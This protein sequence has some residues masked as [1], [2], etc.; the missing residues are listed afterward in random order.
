MTCPS[1][2]R[3]DESHGPLA[4]KKKNKKMCLFYKTCLK[5]SLATG[6]CLDSYLSDNY[7][8]GCGGG[9]GSGGGS[10]SLT[11]F[12]ISVRV[13]LLILIAL[14]AFL[15]LHFFSFLTF[16][17]LSFLRSAARRSPTPVGGESLVSVPYDLPSP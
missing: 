12:P 1:A 3:L 10:G 11:K 13:R 7:G 14:L 4:V 2:P 8:G 6:V 9:G 16:C 17:S 15:F 5:A